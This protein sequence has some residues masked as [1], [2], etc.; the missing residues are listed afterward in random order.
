M[1]TVDIEGAR[2]N[3]VVGVAENFALLLGKLGDMAV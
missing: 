1:A 3:A 2:T